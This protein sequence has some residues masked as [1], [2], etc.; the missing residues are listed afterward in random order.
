[1]RDLIVYSAITGGKDR[2]R[3]DMF[4]SP[5]V[6]YVM[7]TNDYEARSK[8]WEFRDA[9]LAPL[10]LDPAREA[11]WYRWH[12]HLLFPEGALTLWLD[13]NF[14]TKA[15]PRGFMERFTGDP[16]F[17]RHPYRTDCY[18]EAEEHIRCGIDDPARIR[19]QMDYYRRSGYEPGQGLVM[20]GFIGRRVP[21]KS[22]RQ[23]VG[24]FEETFAHV[25]RWSYR[26]QLAVNF[27]AHQFGVPLDCHPSMTEC[28]YF[29]DEPHLR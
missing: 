9:N 16:L 13:G 20:T 23:M 28:E 26:D 1:V 5:G 8:A 6:R 22:D 7:F 10:G 29:G 24:F 15:D 2:I 11:M 19:S 27:V 17:I 3:E 18:Q 21:R 4:Q 12:P 14:N 25:R